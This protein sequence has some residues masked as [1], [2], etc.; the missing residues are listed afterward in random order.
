MATLGSIEVPEDSPVLKKQE[1]N[2]PIIQ[3][4]GNSDADLSADEEVSLNINRYDF[5]FFK[6]LS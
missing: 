4:A 5:Q 6:R 2:I 1:S 3:M